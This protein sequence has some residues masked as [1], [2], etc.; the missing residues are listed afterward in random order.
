MGKQNT[1]QNIKKDITFVYMDAAER[2]A[3]L[4]IKEEAEKRGYTT[5]LTD[6]KFA[7]C[8]IGFYCQHVNFPQYSKFSLIMLH[9]II[10]GSDKWPDLWYYEPWDKYDIGFLPSKQWVNNW[11]QCSEYGYTRP[12]LGMYH[13]GWPK[14]DVII[15]L[16]EEGKREKFFKEHGMD[17]NKKTVLYAPAWEND[18][19]QDDFVQAMLKLDVN[20]LIKQ[21][22]FSETEYPEQVR[23]IAEMRKLHENIPGVTI[24]DPKTN[25]FEAIVVS[26][27][28]V[29]E[30]SSTMVEALM[31][32]IPAVSVTNWLIPDTTPSRESDCHYEFTIT[33]VKEKLMECVDDLLK[34]Y[35][36]T[37]KFAE[38]WSAE[39][40]SNIGHTSDMI[41]DILDAALEGS[42]SPIPCL[43]S[44]TERKEDPARVQKERVV[45][46]KREI[47]FNY[48]VRNK[49][50]AFLFNKYKKIR[51][52][53]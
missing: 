7:K 8:E 33:T 46:V 30:E 37:K 49:F 5:H 36:Q 23:N 27:L 35:D 1:R 48:C 52:Y 11:N 34:N 31:L 13:V 42:E 24:L 20:I 50:L 44:N 41:M 39:T 19:K 51:G 4:P 3:F 10:Q 45:R 53:E 47:M 21:A 43:Q 17:L 25:I 40:F 14:A 6:D 38:D 9:D 15:K 18:G 16:K 22:S 32:G 2:S 29:S 28:L 26:D 12:R